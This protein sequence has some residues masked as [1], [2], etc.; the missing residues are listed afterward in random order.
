MNEDLGQG[1]GRSTDLWIYD[2]LL[3]EYAALGFEYGYAV[4]RPEALVMWE[5]QFGDFANGAQV[6]IDQFIVAAEDKWGQRCG[7]VLLLPHGFE[8]QGPEH[9]SARIERFL[10]LAAEDNIQVCTPT[11][12]A[13]YFHLLRRQVV[14][15]AGKP[16]IIFTP[17]SLL[18][19]RSSRSR[20]AELTSGTFE[21]VLGDST[22]ESA[23]SSDRVTEESITGSALEPV[24]PST[25]RRVLLCS[26]KV[27]YD[28][29]AL[30]DSSGA[31]VAVCRIEQL[32]P[33]PS[34]AVAEQLDRYPAAREIVWLQEEPENMGPWSAVKGRL[35]GVYEGTH[36][37][38]RVSRPES[39][40][41]A[42]GSARVHAQ[43]Q[44][45]L[46]SEAVLD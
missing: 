19:S 27:A 23:G 1:S 37:I 22:A 40:S 16:L 39:G 25:V 34:A 7:I 41:P 24:D 3:S 17:K 20:V 14:R 11:T 28:A 26:G 45:E 33:W 4:A 2:S 32:F 12:A 46:I 8:G 21:E 6:I 31:P 10:A 29:M 9:S 44:T 43:E 5:A 38:R 18:R 15:G 30:R 36:E 42:C 35:Y 13:Q